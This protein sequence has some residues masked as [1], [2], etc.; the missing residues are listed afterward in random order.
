M[1]VTC[2]GSR[3]SVAVSGCQFLKYGGD[4]TCVTVE[5][6]AGDLVIID[7]GT[8]IR[9][10][11]NKIVESGLRALTLLFTHA[12]WDHLLGLPFFKPLYRDH[13]Q[14]AMYGYAFTPKNGIQS[15]IKGIFS[16][17]YFPI[18][19]DAIL[20][21]L[22][23]HDLDLQAFKVGSLIITPIPLNHPDGGY[24]YSIQ[25]GTRRFVFLTDNNLGYQHELGLSYSAYSDF[26]MNAN[27][28]IHDAEFTPH[29][30]K[31]RQQWGHSS[32]EDAVR[33]ASDAHVSTLGLF[34]HN[35][36]RDDAGIDQ[37]VSMANQLSHDAGRSIPCIGI[38]S[39]FSVIL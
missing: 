2:Y 24:G 16:H 9:L 18:N 12:H 15:T 30:Y 26:C 22:D 27:L 35:Q 5:S 1:K 17:P 7:A 29:E 36:D 25:E 37:L 4:T 28:L 11:G 39:G 31:T 23:Y 6:D 19:T 13:F 10:L 34:H 20:A 38:Y 3:G 32:F 14:V 21:K 8:G 33:L